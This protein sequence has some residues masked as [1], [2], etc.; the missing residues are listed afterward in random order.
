VRTLRHQ[1]AEVDHI[2]DDLESEFGT[3]GLPQNELHDFV[4]A[5]KRTLDLVTDTNA[6]LVKIRNLHE[7]VKVRR[8]Q[9]NMALGFPPTR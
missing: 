8:E 5:Y 9:Q 1:A 4:S 2:M 7:I 6:L 3:F